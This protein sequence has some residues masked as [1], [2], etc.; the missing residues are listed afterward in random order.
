M[1]FLPRQ[2]HDRGRVSLRFGSSDKAC[3]FALS[4]VRF[5]CSIIVMLSA[6]TVTSI[7]S[8][9]DFVVSEAHDI[10]GDGISIRAE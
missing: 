4:V 9:D 1:Q 5:A 8:A 10:D 7:A 6:W 2:P 3:S